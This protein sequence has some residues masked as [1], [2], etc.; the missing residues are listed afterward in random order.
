MGDPSSPATPIA[1][2]ATTP[3]AS[4]L[5]RRGPNP[6]ITENIISAKKVLAM[7]DTDDVPVSDLAMVA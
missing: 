2:A 5:P 3:P 6:V 1:G 4:F 7:L